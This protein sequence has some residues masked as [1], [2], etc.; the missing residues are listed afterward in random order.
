MSSPTRSFIPTTF[1]Y[2][3]QLFLLS[4]FDFRLSIKFLCQLPLSSPPASLWAT[5]GIQ[6]VIPPS[7]RAGVVA[8]ES[9]VVSIMMI[10]T[11]PERQEVVQAPRKFIS[12]VGINSLEKSEQNPNVHCK[13]V[14]IACYCAP[15]DW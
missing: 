8:N 9:L 7:E 3:L 14:E 10:S 11:C 15:E 1:T 13:D 6:E 4:T 5:L 12:R 2:K